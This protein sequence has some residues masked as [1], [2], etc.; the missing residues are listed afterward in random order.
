[1]QNLRPQS[2]MWPLRAECGAACMSFYTAF[3]I[4]TNNAKLSETNGNIQVN[5]PTQVHKQILT[6]KSKNIHFSL[7]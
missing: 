5:C 1:M 3:M 2:H 7:I 6:F 4:K